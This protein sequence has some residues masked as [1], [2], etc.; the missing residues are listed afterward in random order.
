MDFVIQS[1]NQYNTFKQMDQ[2]PFKEEL[3]DKTF[4]KLLFEP[5]INNIKQK[6]QQATK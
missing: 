5:N 3:Y 1:N 2:P 6:K 4:F